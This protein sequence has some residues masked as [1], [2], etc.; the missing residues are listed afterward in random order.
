MTF[1]IDVDDEIAKNGN[2]DITISEDAQLQIN[3]NKIKEM[4]IG[5]AIERAT[6]S[7][8]LVTGFVEDRIQSTGVVVIYLIKWKRVYN[9]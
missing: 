4:H 3:Y 2:P 9:D 8:F 5:V 7:G 6:R 1:R